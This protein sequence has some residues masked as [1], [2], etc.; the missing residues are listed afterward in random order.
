MVLSLR[1]VAVRICLSITRTSRRGC[2]RFMMTKQWSTNLQKGER[3]PKQST[4]VPAKSDQADEKTIGPAERR[5]FFYSR[6]D[7]K[8]QKKL[9]L[10]AEK[11]SPN[12]IRRAKC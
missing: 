11:K 9:E 2:G 7:I 1:T 8:T 4:C 12:K 3:G 10:T 6:E 5:G